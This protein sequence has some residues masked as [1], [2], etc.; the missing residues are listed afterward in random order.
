MDYKNAIIEAINKHERIIPD[1]IVILTFENPLRKN[2]I[3]NKL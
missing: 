3:S 2:I 1:L